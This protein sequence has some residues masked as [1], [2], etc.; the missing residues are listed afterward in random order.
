[1][2]I[3]DQV[4]VM[5][6]GEVVANVATKDT[7][8]EHLAELMVGRKVLLRVDKKPAQPGRTVLEV[9][10]LNM[11]DSLKCHRVTNVSFTVRTGES[12]G[13]AGCSGKGQSALLGGRK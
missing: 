11:I 5:R 9:R 13:I 7:D 6:R 10:N 3:T 4:T 8:R 2:A 12:V 1:M